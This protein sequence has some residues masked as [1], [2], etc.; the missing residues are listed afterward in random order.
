MFFTEPCGS[1]MSEHVLSTSIKL[2]SYIF[3]V[4]FGP[5]LDLRT[6][7]RPLAA[8]IFTANACAALATSAFGF[9][10]FIAD[11]F[12]VCGNAR[13]QRDVRDRSF[14]KWG[15]QQEISIMK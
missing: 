5:R 4:P 2:F 9:N 8:L 7:W 15:T 11:I 10:D 13:F 3:K 1:R 14:S 12:V 6:S